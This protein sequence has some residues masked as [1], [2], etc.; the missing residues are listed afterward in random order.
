MTLDNQPVNQPIDAAPPLPLQAADGVG[1]HLLALSFSGG[2]IRAAAFSLGALLALQG[3]GQVPDVLDD[4]QF[5]TAVS[6]GSLTAAYY[7]LYGRE[8][9]PRLR[10]EV[11]TENFELDMRLSAWWPANWLRLLESGGINDRSNL[12]RTLD[13][14]VFHGATFADLYAQR[15]PTVWINA[16]DLFNRIPFT[17]TP[18]VFAALCSDLARLPVAEAVQASMAVPLV[19]APVV[20]KT[21]PDHCTQPLPPWVARADADPD[22]PQ[23]LRAT[24]RAVRNFRDPAVMRYVKL[25]DGGI[26]DNYGLSSILISRS[27]ADTPYGPFTQTDAV[28]MRHMLFLVIDAG[29]GPSGDWA[30]RAD[31]PSGIDMAKLA[32]DTAID[33][34]SRTAY[35]GF[36][37]MV[38]AWHDVIVAYRC[39]LKAAEVQRL[40]GARAAGWDCRDLAF[41]VSLVRF[42]DLDRDRAQRL[43]DI[44]TRLALPVR[45]VEDAVAAGR[46]AVWGNAAFKRYLAER[47]R[48]ATASTT[49]TR[50]SD[51][52]K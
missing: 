52:A 27:V 20:L 25:V 6:G 24:A 9:L 51:G 29:R 10:H 18:P 17:F 47:A 4:T 48:S 39:T 35:D 13:R 1:E 37:M 28:R 15:K 46:D 30:L 21:Y 43:N 42:S 31:G 45:Q 11:L 49:Q 19:F 41:E 26:T 2:G 40:L 3:G 38:R 7:G 32:T 50:A 23:V 36:R 22:A 12:A 34:A 16:T 44:P 33:A 14:R 5:I 8:G